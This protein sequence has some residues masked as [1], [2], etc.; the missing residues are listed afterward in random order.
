[1]PVI[2]TAAAIAATLATWNAACATRRVLVKLSP[3]E[4]ADIGLHPGDIDV[5][6]LMRGR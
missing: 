2:R 1:M 4:L 5:P 6:A 3:R